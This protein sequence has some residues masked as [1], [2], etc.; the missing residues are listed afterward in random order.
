MSRKQCLSKERHHDICIFGST[1]AVD[2][3]SLWIGTRWDRVF[4]IFPIILLEKWS[5]CYILLLL[6]IFVEKKLHVH[7]AVRSQSAASR[8]ASSTESS[9]RWCGRRVL[10]LKELFH[11]ETT[12][13]RALRVSKC[14][15]SISNKCIQI[16]ATASHGAPKG[17]CRDPFLAFR[18]QWAPWGHS[19]EPKR[20]HSFGAQTA[21]VIMSSHVITSSTSS[22][23]V[24]S[25]W[26]FCIFYEELMK[27]TS[28][29]VTCRILKRFGGFANYSIQ[30]IS[31]FKWVVRLSQSKEP[32]KCMHDSVFQN[33]CLSHGSPLWTTP[34]LTFYLLLDLP[35]SLF[36]LLLEIK[37]A[38]TKKKSRRAIMKKTSW[39][40]SG[41]WALRELKNLRATSDTESL[42]TCTE[43]PQ[44]TYRL[45]TAGIIFIF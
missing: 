30:I 29:V 15:L 10:G 22:T 18:V 19:P 3:L 35:K 14:Y 8:V 6:R 13:T 5:F 39:Q 31:W 4:T 34:N 23:S 24:F 12:E 33:A 26:A 2:M 37:S 7:Q 1:S 11:P 9:A 36:A 38:F 28:I 25:F 17:Y 32:K 42:W 27:K 40:E 20:I 44:N 21:H 41:F 16:S 43:C 45:H